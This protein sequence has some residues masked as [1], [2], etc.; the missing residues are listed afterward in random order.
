MGELMRDNLER[1]IDEVRPLY[2]R[3]CQGEGI[4]ASNLYSLQSPKPHGQFRAVMFSKT[5]N[6]NR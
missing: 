3:D 6:K 1:Q 4:G 2:C 5:Q